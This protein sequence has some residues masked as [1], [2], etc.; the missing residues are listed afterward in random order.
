MKSR[1]KGNKAFDLPADESVYKNFFENILEVLYRSDNDERVTLISPSAIRMFGYDSLDDFLGKKIREVFYHNPTDRIV[2][3][4]EL[5]KKGKVVNF[6]LI[7]KKKDGSKLYVKTTSYHIFDENGEMC[8]VEG[9]IMD[10]TEQ[11]FTEQSLKQAAHIVNNIQIGIHIYKLEDPEDDSTFRMVSANPASEVLTGIP[12]KNL[13]GKTLDEC[14]PRLREKGIPKWYAEV[15]R[16]KK[17]IEIE[18]IAYEDENTIPGIFSMKVFPLPDN[19]IGVSFENITN[20]KKTEQDLRR[21]E[22]KHRQLIEIMNE[23]FAILNREGIITYVNK[24]LC[25]MMGYTQS[26]LTGHPTTDFL[27]RANSENM[28]RHVT[29][30]SE[31]RN[32]PYEVEW[33]K[34]NGEKLPAIVSPMP[35]FN[36]SG[37]LEGN[38]A[39]LTDISELKR[40][41]RELIKKNEKL[42]K[43]MARMK[44]LNA[45]L[46]LSEKMASLGQITAGLAHEI[47]NPLSYSTANINPLI[48]DINDIFVIL[49]KYESIIENRNL[50]QEFVEVDDLKNN[51]DYPELVK[52]IKL[53]LEGIKEG[54]SR[55]AKIIKSL[56][57]FSRSG[58]EQPVLGNVHEGIDN[59]LTL[60]AGE[61]ADRISIHKDY[62]DIPDIEYY[63]GKL[64]Q[65]FMNILSN[66]IQAIE[67]RGEIHI[68]T[69]FDGR[70]LKITIS[71]SGKGMPEKVLKRIFEPFYTTKEMGQGSGLGLSICY[72]II[73][74]HHGYINVCSEPGKGTE[75]IITLPQKQAGTVLL[76]E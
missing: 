65:V 9:V 18:D 51:S 64:N 60:L 61:I 66:G 67:D 25:N 48:R 58:E 8:G 32:I 10:Y 69:Q 52:E 43:T 73:S 16:T 26:E 53:L 23:G 50:Q 44:E 46:L 24:R 15:V 17:P 45:Q 28:Q 71:D 4:D 34:K 59:T 29:S 30:R 5:A 12:A 57:N 2:L 22:E 21:S 20:R 13:V 68:K 11:Y 75:F 72:K 40:I 47:K 63:P 36:E 54:T 38:V 41:E 70:N 49:D 1:I 31:G 27:D 7:L 62:G 39:V 37:E 6:P 56:G 74:E 76:A 3:L 42:R 14:F 55:T 35:L 19:Q 33:L